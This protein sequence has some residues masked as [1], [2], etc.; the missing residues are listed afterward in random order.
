[1]L[2]LIVVFSVSGQK[3]Y[4]IPSVYSNISYGV[5]GN[6]MLNIGSMS[7]ILNDMPSDMTLENMIG[8]P[9]TTPTG[10]YFD[11]KNALNN[12]TLYYGLIPYH[13]SKYPLPV[14]F[15][16]PTAIMDGKA[17]VN[18]HALRGRYDMVD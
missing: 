6:L 4:K 5:E 18:L 7:Y 16:S 11:F 9:Q 15:R 1:M 13:D 2:L 10:V 3:R 12:G 14:Y 17:F 8:N